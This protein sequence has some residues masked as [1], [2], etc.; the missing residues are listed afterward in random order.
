[1]VLHCISQKRRCVKISSTDMRK[2]SR[3]SDIKFIEHF[4]KRICKKSLGTVKEL[5]FISDLSKFSAK[6]I[7]NSF[8]EI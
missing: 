3:L 4:Y 6:L 1:M 2:R 7:L 5:I 8:L